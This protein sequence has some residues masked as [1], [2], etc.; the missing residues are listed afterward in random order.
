MTL[1]SMNAFTLG[2]YLILQPVPLPRLPGM[3]NLD[4]RPTSLFFTLNSLFEKFAARL[5][6]YGRSC[7]LR[8]TSR[9]RNRSSPK[10]M[11]NFSANFGQLLGG[12]LLSNHRST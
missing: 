2:I 7:N 5:P 3:S 12:Q 6:P 9:N 4:V 10:F 1:W 11:A 8:L